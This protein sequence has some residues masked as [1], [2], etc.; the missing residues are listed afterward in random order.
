MP[1]EK[2]DHFLETVLGAPK[3][4]EPFVPAE[5]VQRSQYPERSRGTQLHLVDCDDDGGFASPSQ[6]LDILPRIMM[7]GTETRTRFNGAGIL[8]NLV[9][10]FSDLRQFAEELKVSYPNFAQLRPEFDKLK[11]G[12]YK[13]NLGEHIQ[14]PDTMT[15]IEILPS[16]R[17]VDELVRLYM[18]YVESVHRI[19][20]VPSF[21]RELEQFWERR[22]NPNMVSPAFVV[23]LLLVLACAWNL[24]DPDLLQYKN[25]GRLKCFTAAKWIVMAEKWIQ[26]ARIKRPEITGF[27]IYCLLI[28]AQNSQGMKRSKAWLATGTLVKQAMLA[29]YHRD[30]AKYSRISP[31]NKEMRRRLWMAIVELD[32]QVALDRGLPPSV[33]ISDYD[34]A[35]ALNINDDEISETIVELPTE[36]SLDQVTDSSFRAVLIRSLPV[37]LRLCAMIHSPR[38]TCSYEEIMRID[39]ELNKHLSQIPDW[40]TSEAWDPETRQK[41]VLWKALLENI[42]NQNFLSLHTPFAI[43]T[44]REPLFT[45]SARARLEV[46]TTLLSTQRRLHGMSKQLSLCNLGDWTT[47]AIATVC[48]VLYSS[49]GECVPTLLTRT[50]PGFAESLLSLVDAVLL[51]LEG[52]LLLVS[53]GA[54]EYFYT[55]TILAMAKTKL[56]PD[57]AAIYRQQV[58]DRL[59]ALAQA[60]F[61]RHACCSHLG[62]SVVG[63][64]GTNRVIGSSMVPGSAAPSAPVF[65]AAMQQASFT[66]TPHTTEFDPFLDVFDW[67]DLTGIAFGDNTEFL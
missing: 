61:Q 18:T 12:L 45:P 52:R 64:L 56:W 37:R 24:A 31:F 46:A 66:I 65:D 57:Q 47:Q 58:V 33:Q 23:Q 11:R 4:D 30:P 59:L 14:E 8:A 5:V 49:N 55:S 13:N 22:E 48:H 60:L 40:K 35:P 38:I 27:R 42:M 17:V 16:R 36:K 28:I 15:L 62:D 1:L 9:A 67:E 21:L 29:G 39:W 32:L 34:S 25:E 26:N 3:T 41:V 51:S 10:Q 6:Q 2:K 19:L 7:R 43:E 20:H 53:K 63:V 50:L 44:P 54:K